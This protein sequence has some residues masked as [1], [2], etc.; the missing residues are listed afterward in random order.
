MK[1]ASCALWA[2]YHALV[3]LI[4]ISHSIVGVVQA[5]ESIVMFFTVIESEYTASCAT[6]FMS[7]AEVCIGRFIT[8]H[9]LGHFSR[10]F[11]DVAACNN[12]SQLKM[13]PFFIF[14]HNKDKGQLAQ[15][16]RAPFLYSGGYGFES[17]TG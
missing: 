8:Y 5:T 3:T 13:S 11:S 9:V 15:L 16:V 12:L 14:H 10:T 6:M 4:T 17:H 1:S 7:I 2:K